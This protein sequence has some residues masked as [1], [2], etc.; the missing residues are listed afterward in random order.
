MNP[1]EL[2]RIPVTNIGATQQE[3]VALIERHCREDGIYQT[4][5]PGLSFFRLSSSSA[6]ACSIV[7]PFFAMAVQGTKRIA[8]ADE[9]Y[10][11]NPKHY[12][13]TSVGLPLI[14]QVMDASPAAPYLLILAEI[15]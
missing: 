4:P 3:L 8:L 10:E 15:L 2:T 9:V 14:A 11:Y 13:I 12:L 7:K 1:I 6:P 5:I